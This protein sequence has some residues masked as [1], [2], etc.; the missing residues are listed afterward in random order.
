[1]SDTFYQKTMDFENGFGLSIV[2]HNSS[3]GNRSGLFEVA[4]L[5]DGALVYHR[6]FADVRG[7]LDFHGVAKVIDE[8]KA[9]HKGMVIQSHPYLDLDRMAVEM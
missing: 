3:Y 1:M 2:C 9:Y 4:L 7:F 5:K 8:V 6:Y